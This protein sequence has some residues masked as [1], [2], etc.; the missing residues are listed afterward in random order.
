MEITI[1]SIVRAVDGIATSI[2]ADN[3][4]IFSSLGQGL[5]PLTNYYYTVYQLMRA[6]F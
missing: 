5:M 4:D 6:G 3:V 1:G 2:V